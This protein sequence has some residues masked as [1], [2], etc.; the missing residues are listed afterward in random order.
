[1]SIPSMTEISGEMVS[2]PLS[3]SPS[4]SLMGKWSPAPPK[5]PFT[6][7]QEPALEVH[8]VRLNNSHR[9]SKS[10]I[11]TSAMCV[12]VLLIKRSAGTIDKGIHKLDGPL[13]M[14]AGTGGTLSWSPMTDPSPPQGVH[15]PIVHKMVTPSMGCSPCCC[16][17]KALL[18]FQTL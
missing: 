4:D 5:A 6:P 10:W 13:Y 15:I 2:L 1:M 11:P 16:I 14:M 9:D 18:D 12:K 3:P 8:M 7:T 17:L